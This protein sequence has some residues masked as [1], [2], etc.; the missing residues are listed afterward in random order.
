M[1]VEAQSLSTAASAKFGLF[2]AARIR[3]EGAQSAVDTLYKEIEMMV[4]NAMGF[5]A[6]IIRLEKQ[7]KNDE[8]SQEGL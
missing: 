6:R 2:E 5:K 7:K 3:L 8:I 4:K 1:S